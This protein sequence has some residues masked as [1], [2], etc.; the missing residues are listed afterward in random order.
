MH[1]LNVECHGHIY[2]TVCAGVKMHLL[3]MIHAV[4]PQHLHISCELRQSR[5][6]MQAR[7]LALCAVLCMHVGCTCS[8]DIRI[9]TC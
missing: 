3:P 9:I 7:V 6:R 8:S 2:M 1:D 5:S 4:M